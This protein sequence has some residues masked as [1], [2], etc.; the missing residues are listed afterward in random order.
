MSRRVHAPSSKSHPLGADVHDS[1][2]LDS[3]GPPRG[4]VSATNTTITLYTHILFTK[5]LT[6][7]LSIEQSLKIIYNMHTI[8][9]LK[10]HKGVL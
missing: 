2:G 1:I 9:K 5:S 8:F 4:H 7:F 3:S 6:F 10:I